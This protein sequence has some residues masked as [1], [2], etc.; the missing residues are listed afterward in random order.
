[1]N[2]QSKLENV[3][4]VKVQEVKLL[5]KGSVGQTLLAKTNEGEFFVKYEVKDPQMLLC[6]ANGL[7]E[8]RK[9]ESISIPTVHHASSDLLVLDYIKPKQ[10][11]SEDF[12]QFGK[13]LALLHNTTSDTYGFY[14]NNFIGLG[15]QINP[16]QR[17]AWGEWFYNYRLLYQVDLAGPRALDLKE[18][19]QNNKSNILK[20]LP[21]G[22]AASLLHGDLWSGNFIID[23]RGEVWLI[24][25]AVFYGHHEFEF[26]ILELFGGFSLEFFNGYQSVIPFEKGREKRVKLYQAYHLLNHYN[27]FGGGYFDQA[28]AALKNYV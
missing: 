23:E 20:L 15:K 27:I 28:V 5:N 19:L 25:P 17:G 7:K 13:K 26:G 9:S 12:Y 10:P 16:S 8:L 21:D 22:P 14:E 6:E 18:W 2:I 4:N 24:D 1:M 3:L 11:S